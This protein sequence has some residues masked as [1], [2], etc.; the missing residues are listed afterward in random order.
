[1][2]HHRLGGAEASLTVPTWEH[3]LLLHDAEAAA[4]D[5]DG[6]G[7]ELFPGMFRRP[8]L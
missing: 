8:L 7:G 4:A 3:L 2:C 1:M 5:D 6:D